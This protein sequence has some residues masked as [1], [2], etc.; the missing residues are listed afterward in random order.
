MKNIKV[1]YNN[2]KELLK[3]VDLEKVLYLSWAYSRYFNSE[4]ELPDVIEKLFTD[5][6]RND[7]GLKRVLG[8]PEHELEYL[9]KTTIIQFRGF[10]AQSEMIDVFKKTD[11]VKILQVMRKEINETYEN[12][13]KAKGLFKYEFNRLFHRQLPSQDHLSLVKFYRTYFIYSQ[14]EISL[15]FKN[16]FG[17]NVKDILK[18]GLYL[19]FNFLE[20]FKLNSYFTN[21]DLESAEVKNFLSFFA[22]PFNELKRKLE[23]NEHS[24]LN[25]YYTYNPMIERPIIKLRDEYYCPLHGMLINAMTSGLYYRLVKSENFSQQIGFNFEK[26][27]GHLLKINLSQTKFTVIPEIKYNKNQ[28]KSSDW[29]LV[30]TNNIAFIECKVKR[31]TYE[32]KSNIINLTYIENDI[33]TISDAVVQ[34]YKCI[35]DYQLNKINGLEYDNS[36]SIVPIVVTLEEWFT[37]ANPYLDGEIKSN[38]VEKLKL[39]NLDTSYAEKHPYIIMSANTL[40]NDVMYINELGLNDYVSF[41]FS[42][43]IGKIKD[44]LQLEIPFKQEIE[45]AFLTK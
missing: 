15:V 19:Y 42:N 21:S 41:Y 18:T 32:S 5:D 13:L 37:S 25:N 36:L 23:Y 11:Q 40:E 27:I 6:Y 3:Y 20:V 29:I 12:Q 8:I 44:K 28:N 7:K 14:N 34:I 9:I 17:Y 26:Y 31:M 35:N 10:N 38:V 45:T 39:K 22:I 16:I 30:N 1:N 24:G 4:N 43:E 2:L 33:N